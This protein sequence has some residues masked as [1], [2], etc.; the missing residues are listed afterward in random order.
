MLGD[1]YR[2]FRLVQ[3]SQDFCGLA[4]KV[5]NKLNFHGSTLNQTDSDTLVSLLRARKSQLTTRYHKRRNRSEAEGLAPG[6]WLGYVS[7]AGNSSCLSFRQTRMST[8]S[9]ACLR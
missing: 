3:V 9:S 5:R 4:L 6:A 8:T 7:F 2:R 1:Q